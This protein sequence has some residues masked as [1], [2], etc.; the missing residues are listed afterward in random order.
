MTGCSI[1]TVA[2]GRLAVRG[3]LD[4]DTAPAALARGLALLGSASDCEIDLS[5]LSSGDSAGLAVLIEWLASA[6]RRGAKLRYTGVP[7]QMRAIARI[8]ALEDLL[9]AA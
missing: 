9:G 3:E 4:F 7:A 2:P 8:S 1:E 6:R 5:G